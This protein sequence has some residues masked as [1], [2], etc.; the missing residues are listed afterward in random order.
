VVA[1]THQGVREK[2]AVERF[3][4]VVDKGGEALTELYPMSGHGS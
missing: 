3:E 4:T 2:A 1:T